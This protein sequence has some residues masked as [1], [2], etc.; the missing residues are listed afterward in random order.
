MIR[1]SMSDCPPD[2]Y[3]RIFGKKG[4]VVATEEKDETMKDDGR[5]SRTETDNK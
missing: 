4:S 5:T 1:S 3:E 2:N